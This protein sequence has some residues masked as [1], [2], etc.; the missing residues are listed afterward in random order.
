VHFGFYRTRQLLFPLLELITEIPQ[1]STEMVLEIREQFVFLFMDVAFHY[2]VEFLQGA[3]IG[4]YASLQCQKLINEFFHL[5]V[6]VASLTDQARVLP[7]QSSLRNR[8]EDL[9]F[10]RGMN[11]K[12][13]TDLPSKS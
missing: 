7:S 1:L 5:L 6:L 9:F 10:D 13:Q 2:R 8:V 11:L 12:F 4:L 3:L